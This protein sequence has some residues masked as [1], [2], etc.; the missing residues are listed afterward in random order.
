MFK[1]A[2]KA[3]VQL[4]IMVSTNTDH[5]LNKAFFTKRDGSMLLLNK[6]NDF[7]AFGIVVSI[8]QSS[9]VNGLF[10]LPQSSSDITCIFLPMLLELAI[11]TFIKIFK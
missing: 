10:I 6:E 1:M 7:H 2:L 11:L 5:T 8:F 3:H 9:P 4:A